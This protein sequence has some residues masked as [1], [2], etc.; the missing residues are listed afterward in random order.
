MFRPSMEVIGMT[1]E[2]TLAEQEVHD[3]LMILAALPAKEG[4]NEMLESDKALIQQARK[5]LLS[6]TIHT[7]DKRY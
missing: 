4:Y 3:V 7:N 5:L 6:T 2:R 1:R